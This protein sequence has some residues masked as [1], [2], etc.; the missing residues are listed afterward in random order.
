MPSL[1][2]GVPTSKAAGRGGHGYRSSSCRAA[3]VTLT[4][5]N[6]LRSDVFSG[7]GANTKT[8]SGTHMAAHAD[9]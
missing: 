6:S 8:F 9:T 7:P 1:T 2:G 5:A 3:T 4:Q